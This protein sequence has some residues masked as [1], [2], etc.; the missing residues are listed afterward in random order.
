MHDAFLLIDRAMSRLVSQLLRGC[1][2]V[3]LILCLISE[4]GGRC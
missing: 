3:L 4:I 2:L 1:G